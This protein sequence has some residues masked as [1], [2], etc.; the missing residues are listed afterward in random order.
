MNSMFTAFVV[1]RATGSQSVD[2][3]FISLVESYQKTLKMVCTDSL[4]GA[5]HKKGI[6]E[7]KPESLLVVSLSKILNGMPPSL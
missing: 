1:I 2:R 7:I 5:Q 3:G 4:L 6:V